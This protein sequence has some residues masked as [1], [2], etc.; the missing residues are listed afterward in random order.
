MHINGHRWKRRKTNVVQNPGT[1]TMHEHMHSHTC[2]CPYVHKEP[3]CPLTLLPTFRGGSL[4][5]PY[6]PAQNCLPAPLLHVP[7]GLT[8]NPLPRGDLSGFD[9]KGAFHGLGRKGAP[10]RSGKGCSSLSWVLITPL[11]K[12]RKMT[13]VLKVPHASGHVRGAGM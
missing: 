1:H 10:G 7:F 12:E 8:V 13:R 2:A 3:P 11:E 5:C 9:K 4:A 6:I